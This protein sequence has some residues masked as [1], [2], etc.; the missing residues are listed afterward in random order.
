MASPNQPKQQTKQH[1]KRPKLNHIPE[2]ENQPKTTN[3]SHHKLNHTSNHQWRRHGVRCR[4]W[5]A[6]TLGQR[7][8]QRGMGREA[9]GSQKE[10]GTTKGKAKI[11]DSK[12]EQREGL[13]FEWQNKVRPWERLLRS[14]RWKRVVRWKRESSWIGMRELSSFQSLSYFLVDQ[15]K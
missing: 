15:K 7:N 5:E 11:H 6:T 10:R 14:F 12:G 1:P 9:H 3:Q 2:T 4:R 8:P 13:G